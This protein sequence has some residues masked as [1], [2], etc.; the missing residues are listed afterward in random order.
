MLFEARMKKTNAIAQAVSAA[1]LL[2]AAGAVNA[3]NTFTWT[4]QGATTGDGAVTSWSN[5]TAGQGKVVS[6]GGTVLTIS[7]PTT[8]ANTNGISYATGSPAA[9]N[10]ANSDASITAS[11][12]FVSQTLTQYGGGTELAV[13]TVKYSNV[14]LGCCESNP[15]HALD[16]SGPD[17]MI[18][19]TFDQAVS[20]NQLKL[21]FPTSGSYD[22]DVSI[23]AYT[24]LGTLPNVAN[25]DSTALGNSANFTDFN[26]KANPSNVN[27][28]ISSFNTGSG[29]VS[30]KYWLVGAYN[31]FLGT[32]TNLTKNNDFVKIAG[33]G[34]AIPGSSG[35]GGVPE[36]SSLALVGLGLIGG[37]RRWKAKKV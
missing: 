35:G 18:L 34:G 27:G 9:T 19:F 3:A 20:L 26:F 31:S 16:N 13:S 33:L 15:E 5:S 29:A 7:T 8:W 1:V 17:E 21:G 37:M 28:G 32:G 10:N 25:L 2:A 11:T 23:L 24:G 4:Y 30:S 22:T 12:K 36:P 14:T 6:S